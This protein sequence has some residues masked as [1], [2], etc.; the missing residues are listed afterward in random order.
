MGSLRESHLCWMK[1]TLKP[2]KTSQTV[3]KEDGD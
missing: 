3:H 2:R 1:K